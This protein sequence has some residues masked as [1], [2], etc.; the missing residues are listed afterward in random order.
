MTKNG[1]KL[2]DTDEKNE[3]ISLLIGADIAG[4][5][6]TG[7]IIQL[8]RGV[9][10]IETR[11]GLTLLGKDLV[12]D[13][14]EDATLSVLSMLTQEA[15]VSEL[16]KLDTLGI[17]DPIESLSKE[18]RQAEIKTL[19]RSTTKRDEEG[20]YEVLLPWKENHPPL[21]DN[22]DIAEKRLKVVTKRLQQEGSLEDYDTIFKTWLSE[23]IIEKVSTDQ[24]NI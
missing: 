11:L 10:A 9:T 14:K 3:A 2:S 7:K 5:L 20:R 19:F 22:R 17:T 18:A 4:K 16:W 6:F 15:S 13:S 23:G 24:V 1:V 8:S 21:P 12:N